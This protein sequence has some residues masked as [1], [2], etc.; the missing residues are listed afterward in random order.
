MRHNIDKIFQLVGVAEGGYCNDVDDPGG[1][2]KYGITIHDVCER[3]RVKLTRL[4]YG[5]MTQK[6]KELTRDDA[7]DIYENKYWV[8]ILGDQL[9]SG[10]DYLLFD[11]GINAGPTIAIKKAQKVLGLEQD[12]QLGPKTLRTLWSIEDMADFNERYFEA[13]MGFYQSLRNW[14]AFGG[15]WTNRANAV[16]KRFASFLVDKSKDVKELPAETQI[17]IGLK[18]DEYPQIKQEPQVW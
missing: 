16:K 12:M 8:P 4:N 13:K 2:T 11:F 14:G 10:I 1:P 3:E 7:L 17:L 9:P 18:I 5:D 6:V 15:G